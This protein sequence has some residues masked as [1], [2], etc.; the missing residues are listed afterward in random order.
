MFQ[1]AGKFWNWIVESSADPE[2]IALTVKGFFALGVVQAVFGLLSLAG[3]H[4]AFS[5][6]D[7]GTATYSVVYLGS[8]VVSSIVAAYGSVRKLIN[9]LRGKSGEIENIA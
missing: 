5:L 8:V 2:K 1:K 3:V 4:P 6:N 9:L 7:L